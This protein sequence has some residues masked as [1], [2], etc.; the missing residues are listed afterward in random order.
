VSRW[1]MHNSGLKVGESLLLL[2][3]GCTI[4]CILKGCIYRTDP[5]SFAPLSKTVPTKPFDWTYTTTYAGHPGPSSANNVGRVIETP[6][7]KWLY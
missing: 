2:A 7:L 1:V 5:S 3:F 6:A 4:E